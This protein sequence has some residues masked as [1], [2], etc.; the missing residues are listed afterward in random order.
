MP[1]RTHCCDG[2]FD[3]RARGGSFFLNFG[4][5]LAARANEFLVKQIGKRKWRRPHSDLGSETAVDTLAAYLETGKRI[6]A[7]AA[8]SG[9]VRPEN[10]VTVNRKS[11]RLTAPEEVAINKRDVSWKRTGS[12][13]KY[14]PRKK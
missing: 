2:C 9:T 3:F 5:I 6:S 7:I 4:G 11:R 1:V 10:T 12:F 14:D 8:A 13:V